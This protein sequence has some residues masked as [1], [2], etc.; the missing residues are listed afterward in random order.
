MFFQIETASAA[1]DNDEA[2]DEEDGE[3]TDDEEEDD[4]DNE[5]DEEIPAVLKGSNSSIALGEENSAIVVSLVIVNRVLTLLV[6][7][8]FYALVL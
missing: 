2:I 3:D 5:A 7:F 4:S 6:S 8:L 1:S